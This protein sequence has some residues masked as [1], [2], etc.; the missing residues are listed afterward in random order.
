MTVGPAG[1][2]QNIAEN[3]FLGTRIND[4]TISNYVQAELRL[5]SDNIQNLNAGYPLT[6][7]NSGVDNLYITSTGPVISNGFYMDH[8]VTAPLFP[9]ISQTNFYI[10]TTDSLLQSINVT[11]FV[12]TYQPIYEYGQIA[13]YSTSSLTQS[14][15][16]LGITGQV[17][18]VDTSTELGIKWTALNS[19]ANGRNLLSFIDNTDT[20]ITNS[21]TNVNYISLGTT[22]VL[23]TGEY[24][25][26]YDITCNDDPG[27]VITIDINAESYVITNKSGVLMYTN[28]SP[29]SIIAQAYVKNTPKCSIFRQENAV[30]TRGQMLLYSTFDIFA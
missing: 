17:L 22:E 9:G 8:S 19:I 27:N 4:T 7:G 30:I 24:Y 1:P 26:T 18:T 29:S 28:A 14:P 21:N 10:S 25:L 23:P 3:M 13:S 11:G 2:I 20:F 16:S 5:Y 15:L 12:T 6:I